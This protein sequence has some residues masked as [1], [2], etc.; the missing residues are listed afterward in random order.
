V[1]EGGARGQLA[2]P[3]DRFA[4]LDPLIRAT[5][6]IRV[7]AG[8]EELAEDLL[9]MKKSSTEQPGCRRVAGF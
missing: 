4:D 3:C 9:R 2:T 1:A 7:L 5:H 8:R 6:V